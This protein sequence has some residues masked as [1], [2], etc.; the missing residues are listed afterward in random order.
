MRVVC[1]CC[2]P[3]SPIRFHPAASSTSWPRLSL[4]FSTRTAASERCSCVHPHCPSLLNS[5]P[6]HLPLP[7]PTRLPSSSIDHPCSLR[8]NLATSSTSWMHQPQ[9]APRWPTPPVPPR[10]SPL[11][12]RQ[13]PPQ[14][15]TRTEPPVAP[16]V[17]AAAAGLGVSNGPA[18]RGVR[19]QVARRRV[20]EVW[21]AAQGRKRA[22]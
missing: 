11:P 9:R 13:L 22:W 15:Q 14:T 18:P 8:L 17:A 3:F 7:R 10:P 19:R 5:H 1:S 20:W 21:G 2:A 12:S 16:P 6:A 4:Q